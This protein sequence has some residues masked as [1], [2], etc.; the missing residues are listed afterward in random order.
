M[1]PMYFIIKVES[2]NFTLTPLLKSCLCPFDPVLRS[3]MPH[4]LKKW[5]GYKS[6]TVLQKEP[7]SLCASFLKVILASWYKVKRPGQPMIGLQPCPLLG[8]ALLNQFVLSQATI[9]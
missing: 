4:T 3:K 9:I 2:L 5:G 6:G 8:Q 1:D 7:L